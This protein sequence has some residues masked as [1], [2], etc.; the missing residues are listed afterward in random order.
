MTTVVPRRFLP[1]LLLEI[2]RH[3]LPGD[4]VVSSILN[5]YTVLVPANEAFYIRTLKACLPRLPAPLRE[6]AVAFIHQEA[7]H[8]VAHKRYWRNLDAQGYRYRGFERAIDRLVF[9]VMD[10]IAPLALRLSLVSCVEHI[11]V[12]LGHEFLRQRILERAHPDMRVLMEWHFAEEIEH[13]AVAYD[14]L[15]TVSRS[16]LLRALGCALTAS[17]FYTVMSFGM[18]RFLAQDGLLFRRAT[19]RALWRHLGSGHGMAARTLRHLAA[20]LRPG[21]HPAQ[22]DDAALAHEVIARATRAQPPQVVPT[23]RAAL[24]DDPTQADAA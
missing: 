2:P 19:W 20:Y 4:P 9:R 24:A 18:L 21:F 1:D 23:P 17:L 22:L 12:Y 16:W 3:W 13:K 14:V 6:Q 10:R 15:N 8:G 7:Q 11:N 5:T